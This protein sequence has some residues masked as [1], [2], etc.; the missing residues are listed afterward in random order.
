[1][2]IHLDLASYYMTAAELRRWETLSNL[3]AG[4]ATRLLGAARPIEAQ[5]R[6]GWRRPGAASAFRPIGS[7]FVGIGARGLSKEVAEADGGGACLLV[8]ATKLAGAER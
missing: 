2:R 8:S 1:V 6:F 3:T 4:I 5:R 7:L